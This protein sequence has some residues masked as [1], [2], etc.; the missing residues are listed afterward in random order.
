MVEAKSRQEA[1]VL[2]RFAAHYSGLDQYRWYHIRPGRFDHE[3][4]CWLIG[5]GVRKYVHC[6]HF[7]IRDIR[8]R[9]RI[10][11]Y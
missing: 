4:R 5:Y 3:G 6:A 10:T 9:Q 2:P 11:P 1:R 8:V 7:E